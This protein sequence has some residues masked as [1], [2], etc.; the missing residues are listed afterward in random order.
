[1]RVYV[2]DKIRIAILGARDHVMDTNSMLH[3][4]SLSN[5]RMVLQYF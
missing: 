1:M 5:C 3:D 2:K 4:V